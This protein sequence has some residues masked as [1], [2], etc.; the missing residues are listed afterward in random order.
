M[1]MGSRSVVPT[2]RKPRKVGQPQFLTCGQKPNLGQPP[3]LNMKAGPGGTYSG[4]FNV[5]PNGQVNWKKG[6]TFKVITPD[7]QQKLKENYQN[8]NSPAFTKGAVLQ[9]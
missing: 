9:P 8:L 4:Y 3:L 7:L 5:P 1:N 6:D 2:F